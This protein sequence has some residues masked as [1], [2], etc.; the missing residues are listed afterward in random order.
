MESERQKAGHGR[1]SSL[2]TKQNEL[3]VAASN[4]D[5]SVEAPQSRQ[6]V[7]EVAACKQKEKEAYSRGDAV[8]FDIYPFD[9][10]F[11]P[12]CP[13]CH[14]NINTESIILLNR[15]QKP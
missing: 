13:F 5:C 11:E 6:E 14:F 9:K 10:R 15:Q 3:E 12:I 8:S 7:P 1:V 2:G 4:R